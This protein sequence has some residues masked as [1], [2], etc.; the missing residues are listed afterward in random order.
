MLPWVPGRG[1]TQGNQAI[2]PERLGPNF[3]DLHA[4]PGRRAHRGARG[5]PAGTERLVPARA[6]GAEDEPATV[7]VDHEVGKVTHGGLDVM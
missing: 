1:T 3:P 5:S 7:G 2:S 6:D 4:A